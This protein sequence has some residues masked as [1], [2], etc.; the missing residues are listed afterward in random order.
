M[1]GSAEG[2][3]GGAKWGG[4]FSAN[5]ERGPFRL[6]VQERYIGGGVI[7]NTVDADGNP[8]PANAEFNANATGNGLVPNHID[9]FWYTDVT[10]TVKVPTRVGEVEWFLTVNN[11][12][13]KD[14]PIIPTFL[15]YGNYPTNAQ[16]YD[17][18][19]RTF[20]TGVRLRF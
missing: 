17:V 12:F 10:A 8:I 11:L 15:F 2:S 4:T 20:T 19:G 9:A 6:F 18:I 3:G 16:V 14:P 5:F 13:N 7:D 1:S